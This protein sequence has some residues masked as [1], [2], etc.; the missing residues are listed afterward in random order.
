MVEVTGF[1]PGKHEEGPY[2]TPVI[3][4]YIAEKIR[5]KI[6]KGY[7]QLKAKAHDNQPCL[8][9]LYDNMGP[10]YH[11]NAFTITTAMYGEYGGRLALTEGPREPAQFVF[12]GFLGN[13]RTTRGECKRLSAIGVLKGT[14]NDVP[15][16]E[17]FH[18]RFALFPV[19][20]VAMAL[21]ADKQFEH[22]NPHERDFTHWRP[23]DVSPDPGSPSAHNSSIERTEPAA[24]RPARRSSH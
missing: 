23:V 3:G 13:R 7:P 21:L 19:E 14:A 12:E 10:L 5:R 11:I 2:A 1:K 20:P 16:L 17:V 18:N 24:S 9:V 6:G 4:A 22:P 15:R 8:L